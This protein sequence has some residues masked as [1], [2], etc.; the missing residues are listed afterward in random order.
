[1]KP[2]FVYFATTFPGLIKAGRFKEDLTVPRK[3]RQYRTLVPQFKVQHAY[4]AA[5]AR[6]EEKRVL[7]HL[8]LVGGTAVTGA[9]RENFTLPLR[10]AIRAAGTSPE[11]LARQA[12][13]VVSKLKPGAE[14]FNVAEL[15][16]YLNNSFNLKLD[17]KEVQR[18]GDIRDALRGIGILAY[19]ALPED[20]LDVHLYGMVIEPAKLLR[21]CPALK[22]CTTVLE[23]LTL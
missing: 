4:W 19:P 15:L 17:C 21:A 11:E 22:P 16:A 8:R 6:A 5:D 13:D 14:K 3:E 1:M 2:G 12:R 23:G 20:N 18:N 10:E 7:A 9:G